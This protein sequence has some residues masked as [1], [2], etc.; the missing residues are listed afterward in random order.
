MPSIPCMAVGLAAP[1][2]PRPAHSFVLRGTSGGLRMGQ[3]RRAR[4]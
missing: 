2:E 1:R 4:W 3:R